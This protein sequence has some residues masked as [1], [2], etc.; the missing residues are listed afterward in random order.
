MDHTVLPANYTMSATDKCKLFAFYLYRVDCKTQYDEGRV[1]ERVE[2]KGRRR[3][4]QC[5]QGP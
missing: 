2:G 3:E 1:N 4:R 5:A